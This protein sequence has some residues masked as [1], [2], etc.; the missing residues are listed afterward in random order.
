MNDQTNPALAVREWAERQFGDANLSD[1]RRVDRVVTIATAMALYPGRS[2]PQLFAYRYDVKAAYTLF[3]HEEATP[4]AL[5]AGHRDM[6]A[7]RLAQP[8]TYLLIEDTTE[9]IY[10]G[11]EPI[12]GLGPVGPLK[13]GKVGFHL[14]SVLAVEWQAV[15]AEDSEAERRQL[16]GV[17]DQ[18]YYVRKPRPE[19][20]SRK[21][22]SARK[23]RERESQLW[24]W[25]SERLGPAPAS[26]HVRW[27][28]VADAGSD[29]YEMLASCQA[30]GHGYVLRSGQERFL[31]EEGSGAPAGSLWPVA[32]AAAPLARF[33]IELRARPRQPARTATLS[34]SATRVC[35]R[36]PQRPGHGPGYLPAIVCTAVRVWEAE[37]PP[38]VAEALEWVL[39]CDG[40]RTS[41]EAALECAQQYAARWLVEEYHKVL[42]TGMGAERVQM[43]TAERLFA[44]VAVM[45]VVGLRLLNVRERARLEP[46]APASSSGLEPLELAVLEEATHR[47]LTTVREV[48]LALGRLGGHM[49]RRSD[50]LPGWQTLWH[51]M[52]QLRALVDGVRLAKKL[53]RFGV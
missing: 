9:V 1:V 47:T 18:Q 27:V 16:L 23:G 34:V 45:S 50:G 29:V 28:R 36:A 22:S 32:R 11:R 20:E 15:T 48:A 53:K 8:G 5:Q 17:A 14:H 7:D 4:D 31:V 19:G 6:L 12:E 24:E 3:A 49:N 30:L 44:A 38:G 10:G 37:P 21:A 33:Q 2:I 39:L 41:A 25:A 40:D 51:G 13:S 46:Q 43:E 35:I 26:Q 42:K 52:N